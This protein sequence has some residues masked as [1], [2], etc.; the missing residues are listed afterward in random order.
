VPLAPVNDTARIS[1]VPGM[2]ANQVSEQYLRVVGGQVHG[3]E[4]EARYT[5]GMDA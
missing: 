4:G 1:T 2:S 3:N 5:M